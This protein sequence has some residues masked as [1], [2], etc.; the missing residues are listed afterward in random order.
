[1]NGN[2]SACTYSLTAGSLH[3]DS[4][5]ETAYATGKLATMSGG[6]V[7]T[8]TPDSPSPLCSAVSG[9][10]SFTNAAAGRFGP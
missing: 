4:W 7:M 6:A 1:M 2:L 5:S 8:L 9:D 3:I 10:M